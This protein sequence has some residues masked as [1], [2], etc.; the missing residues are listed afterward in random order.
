MSVG[1]APFDTKFAAIHHDSATPCGKTICISSHC[2]GTCTSATCLSDATTTFPHTDTN[3]SVC[4]NMCKL[5]VATLRER[6]ITFKAL[7]H[8]FDMIHIV[9][10]Y[11]VMRISH[12]HE[13]AGRQTGSAAKLCVIIHDRTSHIDSDT[14]YH[15]IRHMQPK[16]FYAG[17]REQPDFVLVGQFSFKQVFAYAT[18]SITTH[19]G[20]TTIGIKYA[21]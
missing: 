21:H 15:A 14:L 20:L 16:G 12:R 7:A 1:L 17:K 13:S 4:H 6:V 2:H 8:R 3:T 5:Y 11:H 19:H 10:E 18:R 9:G